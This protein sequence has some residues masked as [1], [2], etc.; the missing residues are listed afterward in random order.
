MASIIA[1]AAVVL[2]IVPGLPIRQFALE[3]LAEQ[4]RHVAAGR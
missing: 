2:L 1:S 3:V 4:A